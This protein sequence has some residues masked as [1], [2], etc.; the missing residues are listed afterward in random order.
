M[1]LKKRKIQ[2]YQVFSSDGS[3]SP[4][5]F[6]CMLYVDNNFTPS[7]LDFKMP[8]SYSHDIAKFVQISLTFDD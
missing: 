3:I 1:T 5:F 7:G 4:L 2:P 8:F 6:V